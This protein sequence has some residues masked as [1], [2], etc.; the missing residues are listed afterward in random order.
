MSSFKKELCSIPI[1]RA[2]LRADLDK[3]TLLV[4]RIMDGVGES[5][6]TVSTE[7]QKTYGDM[8]DSVKR[9]I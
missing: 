8:V 7:M 4:R 6:S 1:E 3:I 5:L 9:K 2:N